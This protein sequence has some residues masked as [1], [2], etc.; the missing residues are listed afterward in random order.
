MQAAP[1]VRVFISYAH[2]DEA[3]RERL[4][5]HLAALARDGLVHAW[6][7][8]EILGGDDWA[9]EIDERLNQADV[10]LLLVT[11]DFIKSD[12]CYGKELARALE[13]NADPADRAIVIPV[14]LRV[15]DWEQSAFARLQALP[16][17]ARP[18]STWPTEDDHY[19]A[20]AK[21]LR[22][23]IRR[24]ID[25]ESRWIDR[26]GRR[27]RD[28]LWWQQ[29]SVWAGALAGLLLVAAGATWWWQAAAQAD[30]DV[31]AALQ[32]M[33]S[34]RYL[35]AMQ[36]VEP[37]CRRLV[38]RDACFV[39]EKARLGVQLETPDRLQ[40]EQFGA[41][42]NALKTKAPDDPDL[43]LFSAELALRGK[44]A[45]LRAQALADI[46]RA[47]KL[48]GGDFPEASF[49]LANL[50][51]LAGRHAEALP[52]L[53]QALRRRS[54]AP[55]HYLNARAYAR[56][57]TGDI[58]GAVQDYEDSA[59]LGSIESRIDLAEL[60]WGR[61]EFH[62]ASDQLR[63]ASSALG[64]DGAAL[65]GR[66]ALPWARETAQGQPVLLKQAVEK[67]C[68]ARWMQRAGLALEGR[69]QPDAAPTWD[70]CG[71]DATRIASAVAAS[72]ARAVKAGMN[73]DGRQHAAEFARQHH[74]PG[75]DTQGG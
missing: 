59:Q 42:V 1:G 38:S 4:R 13:R 44:R 36:G 51:L 54:V 9:D 16:P 68:Y 60:F 40:A 65:P 6:D 11:A 52:L 66:N 56:A 31:A 75:L 25:P 53:D 48:A 3:L 47:I 41:D 69:P 20:V 74:L 45:D 2:V 17:G 55:D 7:D 58:A 39:L 72:L 12:Y 73:D 63:A 49:Y 8:R 46:A 19:T 50:E 27:L 70:D 57:R 23:R 22:Q 67:R 37:V 28:P 71:P 24:A 61:S 34:G 30:G 32:A 15:C 5:T 10:I 35:K 29:P 21:G 18:I 64:V 26:L 62:R 14:I 33:R 43:V